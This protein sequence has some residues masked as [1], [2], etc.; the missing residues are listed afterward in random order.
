MN[1]HSLP[2]MALVWSIILSSSCDPAPSAQAEAGQDAE[3]QIASAARAW[4]AAFVR[5]DTTAIGDLYTSDAV[6][7]LPTEEARGRS[8]ITALFVRLHSFPDWQMIS[9]AMN[10]REL[11]VTNSVAVDLG[12]WRQSW[13]NVVTG[14]IQEPSAPYLAVWLRGTDGQWRMKYDMAYS[15]PEG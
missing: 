4:S 7:L 13:R 3:A 11:T 2:T 1:R 10:S 12:E 6:V 8:A 9:H 14:E 5:G 15:P